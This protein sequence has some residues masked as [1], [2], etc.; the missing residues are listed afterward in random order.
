M[1]EDEGGGVL[2]RE[3]L[4]E[5]CEEG[6]LAFPRLT[7]DHEKSTEMTLLKAVEMNEGLL[8]SNE[9]VSELMGE[10]L[11]RETFDFERMSYGLFLRELRVDGL[12]QLMLDLEQ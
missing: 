9:V 7:S 6:R 12:P 8:S 11:M 2:H 10:R 1:G 5:V 4:R 3:A